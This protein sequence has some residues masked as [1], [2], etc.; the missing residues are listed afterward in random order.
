M[1]SPHVAGTAALVLASGITDADGLYGHAN[2]VRARFAQTAVDLGPA[3]HDPQYGHGLVDAAAAVGLSATDPEDGGDGGGDGGGGDSGIS[4]SASGR[5]V[6]GQHTV[7]LS[8][9][10]STGLNVATVE[11]LRNGAAIAVTDNDGSMDTRGGA[12]YTYQVCH[13]PDPATGE[14]ICSNETTVGF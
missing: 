8:W 1:S 13:P 5:K 3:D 6:Q 2:E 12:S 14:M 11:V 9:T 10:D 7:D 4:L